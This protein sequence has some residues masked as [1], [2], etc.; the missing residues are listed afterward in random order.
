MHLRIIA[1][2]RV[3]FLHFKQDFGDIVIAEY[4]N[5]I[6]LEAKSEK[7]TAVMLT[8]K[9]E[10]LNFKILAPDAMVSVLPFANI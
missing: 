3:T 2:A 5:R 1:C 7:K 9:F 4:G 10:I 8:Y 6:R